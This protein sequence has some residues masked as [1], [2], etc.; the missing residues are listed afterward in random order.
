MS[1]GWISHLYYWIY[2]GIMVA[3]TATLA[4]YLWNAVTGQTLS[5]PILAV[6]AIVFAVLSGYIAFR[7]ISGSTNTALVITVIQLAAIVAFTVF[8][9]YFRM[10][11]PALHY[12]QR[13]RARSVFTPHSF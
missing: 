12:E 5:F 6:I 9:I 10:A 2:P 13:Q 11:H 7:G 3:Y 4:G 1:L 8:A